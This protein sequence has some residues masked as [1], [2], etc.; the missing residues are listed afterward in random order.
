MRTRT[1]ALIAIGLLLGSGLA[2]AAKIRCEFDHKVDFSKLKTYRWNVAQ[3][4]AEESLDRRVRAEARAELAKKGL[5]EL[6]PG[7]QPADLVLRYAVGSVDTLSSGVI[8]ESDW[9]GHLIAVPGSHSIVTGG[10]L[11]EMSDPSTG[12]T[13][14]V[15]TYIMQGNTPQALQVMVDRAEKAVRGVCKK[16]PPR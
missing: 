16:Y 7:D 5:Q 2:S 13:L 11:L 1:L 9:Y 10:L 3:G 15:A 12:K 8:L 4:P 14:W 6:P